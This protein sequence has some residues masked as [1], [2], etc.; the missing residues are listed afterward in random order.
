LYYLRDK[1][2]KAAKISEREF[3]R[4]SKTGKKQAAAAIEVP[5]TGEAESTEESE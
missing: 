1:K 5:S 2:G 3:S 4:V